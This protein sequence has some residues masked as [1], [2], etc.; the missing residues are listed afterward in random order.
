M[1]PWG[2]EA[3]A[4]MPGLASHKPDGMAAGA[5]MC[6]PVFLAAAGAGHDALVARG[7][8]AQAALGPKGFGHVE[9]SRMLNRMEGYKDNCMLFLRDYGMPF[10]NNTGERD[11]RPAKTRQKVS[12]CFRAWAGRRCSPRCGASPRRWRNGASR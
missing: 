11:L 6:D 1:I 3:S 2:A 7:R 5:A 8:A 10:T 9:P 12:G 4:F